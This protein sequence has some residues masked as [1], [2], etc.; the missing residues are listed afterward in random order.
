MSWSVV[1]RILFVAAVG[2][3]AFQ[4]TPLPVNAWGNAAFGA[5]LGSL[6]VAA[7]MRQIGRAH[8]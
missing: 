4:V 1:A 6:I 2:Y 5:L 3:S 7:E 8:V